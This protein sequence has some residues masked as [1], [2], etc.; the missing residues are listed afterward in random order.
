MLSPTSAT[1]MRPSFM[2]RRVPS[3]DHAT[4]EAP[5]A[6]ACAS[7]PS[8]RIAHTWPVERRP[9]P[10]WT[11]KATHGA[12]RPEAVPEGS[13]E[14]DGTGVDGADGATDADSLGVSTIAGSFPRPDP[15]VTAPATRAVRIAAAARQTSIAHTWPVERRP[16]PSW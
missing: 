8:A 14:L 4:G 5:L 16:D 15:T 13:G 6:I 12:A 3:G 11:E 2:S 7:L 10:S 9:D 1:R